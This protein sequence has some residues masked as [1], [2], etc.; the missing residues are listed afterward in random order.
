MAS[1]AGNAHEGDVL[2]ASN[3]PGVMGIVQD[4]KHRLP[5]ARFDLESAGED[6][7][8]YGACVP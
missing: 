6:L 2:E 7:F 3:N 8:S 4:L 1:D 5:G